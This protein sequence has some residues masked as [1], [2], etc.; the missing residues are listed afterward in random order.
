VNFKR[1]VLNTR[2]E[3]PHGPDLTKQTR[4][5][6]EHQSLQQWY[7]SRK[8]VLLVII[9][10]NNRIATSVLLMRSIAVTAFSLQIT[11]LQRYFSLFYKCLSFIQISVWFV[12]WSISCLAWCFWSICVVLSLFSW[13]FLMPFPTHRWKTKQLI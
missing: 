9:L 6:L 13:W 7:F 1:A 12:S 5:Y 2:F 3:I 4:T 8:K 10:N 11:R